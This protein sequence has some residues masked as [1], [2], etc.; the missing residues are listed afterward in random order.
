M[1]SQ[2]EGHHPHYVL[3]RLLE[4]WYLLYYFG[5]FTLDKL[6]VRVYIRCDIDRCGQEPDHYMCHGIPLLVPGHEQAPGLWIIQPVWLV[7]LYAFELYAFV[8]PLD[9]LQPRLRFLYRFGQAIS[10]NAL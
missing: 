5:L 10:L 8:Q 2:V 7:S 6:N 4:H 1:Y 9:R 3:D